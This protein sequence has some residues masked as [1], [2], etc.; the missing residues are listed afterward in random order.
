[1]Y[2][3]K[4]MRKMKEKHQKRIAFISGMVAGVALT[5]IAIAIRKK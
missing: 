4:H 1:M 3:P 5:K 2:K